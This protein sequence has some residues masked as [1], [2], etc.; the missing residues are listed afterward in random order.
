LAC[1]D[2]SVAGGADRRNSPRSFEDSPSLGHVPDIGGKS[3]SHV[4][5]ED[6]IKALQRDEFSSRTGSIRK[7][8]WFADQERELLWRRGTA[9]VSTEFI[10]L[11]DVAVHVHE[12]KLVEVGAPPRSRF[13]DIGGAVDFHAQ[14]SHNSSTQIALVG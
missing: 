11:A 7:V 9:H 2:A 1:V 8:L 10:P 4:A 12:H 14:F 6:G 5:N 3:R 13:A